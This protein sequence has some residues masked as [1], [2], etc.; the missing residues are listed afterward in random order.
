MLA[1]TRTEAIAETE[2]I[3]LMDALQ[4]P[5]YRL[6]DDLVFQ[7]SDAQRSLAAVGLGNPLSTRRLSPVG[8]PVN[9]IMEVRNVDL[10]VLLVVLPCDPVHTDGRRPLQVEECFG[11]AVFI[12][13]V[14]QGCEFER[15]VLSGSFTHAAQTA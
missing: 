5:K 8:S 10:H 7:R 15:A 3:L 13:M 4:N 1:A 14:Q 12:D 9:P 6:L 11:Q 2:K